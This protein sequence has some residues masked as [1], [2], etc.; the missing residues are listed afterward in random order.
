MR[1]SARVKLL[2]GLAGVVL[3][4]GG[5]FGFRWWKRAERQ[6][7]AVASLPRKPAFNEASAELRERVV[8]AEEDVRRGSDPIEG[9][10]RLSRLYD[11][12]GY[13]DAALKC[14]E[15]LIR[16]EPGEPKWLHLRATLLAGF[17]QLDEAVPLWQSMLK[18]SPAYEPA[19]IHLTDALLKLNRAKEA[20]SVDPEEVRRHT[21]GQGQPGPEI[22]DPWKDELYEYCYD[23]YKLRVAA[24]AFER[25]SNL[26]SARATLEH[27]LRLAPNDQ[28]AHR[29]L[30][31]L[32]LDQGDIPS[33]RI[34]LEK[35]ASLG[36][37]DSEN[38]I[39]LFKLATAAHDTEAAKRVVL[40]GLS[41]CPNSPT[42]RLEHGRQLLAAR[43]P[44]SA[45]AE[46]IEA[47]RLRPNE[48]DPIV[49]IGIAYLYLGETAKGLA[50]MKEVL[51]VQP[52]HPMAL[53][54]LGRVAIDAGDAVEARRWIERLK[55]QARA[56]PEDVHEVS[57]MFQ[58]RFGTVP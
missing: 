20:E 37:D 56:R 51:R 44:Q 50:A 22:A 23:P 29:E 19:R 15:G 18:L 33:A 46:F 39:G 11:A 54:T 40:A 34:H 3:C 5:F 28:A 31:R 6:S 41:H 26:A 25:Q 12:N 48:P 9:L 32:F 53:L 21:L 55:Q 14:Y 36:P 24:A 10:Q 35:A 1:R 58:Q 7:A 4:L 13:T 8:Q 52:D 16:L 42:L 17:G 49:Q 2:I 47:R 45:L 30:G 57:A 27:A 38:W 43:D